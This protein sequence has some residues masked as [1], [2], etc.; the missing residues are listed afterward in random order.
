MITQTTWQAIPKK[1]IKDT[2]S[3]KKELEIA[4]TDYFRT[5]NQGYKSEQESYYKEWK[6]D[7][8]FFYAPR[9]FDPTPFLHE[10]QE[11]RYEIPIRER[12]ILHCNTPLLPDQH[13]SWDALIENNG[14]I[15]Q[16]ACG[17]G[18]T[19]LGIKYICYRNHTAMVV[20]PTD[21]L[22][23]QWKDEFL[24]FT[25]IDENDIGMVRGR[26][27]FD[28]KK[29]VVI[30]TI[31]SLALIDYEALYGEDYYEFVDYFGT[32]IFDECHRLKAEHFRIVGSMFSGQRVGFSA[33]ALLH[34]GADKLYR[35]HLGKVVH[36]DLEQPMKPKII[37]VETDFYVD[38]ENFRKK[39]FR[40]DGEIAWQEPKPNI[41]RMDTF[42]SLSE[43]RNN[44]IYNFLIRLIEKSD[45]YTMVIGKRVDQ[46]KSLHT[47]L[48]K[49]VRDHGLLGGVGLIVGSATSKK[50]KAARV[51]ELKKRLVFGSEK[52]VKEGLNIQRMDRLVIINAVSDEVLFQQAIGRICREH[53]EK[54]DPLVYFFVDPL[55]KSYYGMGRKLLRLCKKHGYEYEVVQVKLN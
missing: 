52:I 21:I 44:L 38:Q 23:D 34:T 42:V 27:K 9:F 18:K 43:K 36:S 29:K 16:L 55:I 6:E 13:E 53:P 12:I 11:I 39:R 46:L 31:Q 26:N 28:Y 15:L 41:S 33:T 20:V 1:C 8:Q 54:N 7:D 40:P 24:Q 14:Q 47:A 3:L 50:K 10:P 37:F 35:L 22:A 51:E 32:I 17:R 48:E 30:S 4:N 5:V 25:D 49:Y 45:R 2:V 19:F